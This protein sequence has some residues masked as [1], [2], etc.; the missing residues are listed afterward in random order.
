[1][2]RRSLP[3]AVLCQVTL[4]TPGFKTRLERNVTVFLGEVSLSLG[5][6]LR[7]HF[8]FPRT[9]TFTAHTF[10]AHTFRAHTVRPLSHHTSRLSFFCPLAL[11][12]YLTLGVGH[13][14]GC[15]CKPDA[16]SSSNYLFSPLQRCLINYILPRYLILFYFHNET[17]YGYNNNGNA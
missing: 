10:R 5:I 17:S 6:S 13:V 14:I 11:P 3:S 7:E 12:P 8:W 16:L 15:L 2:K 9:H 1:M 4:A